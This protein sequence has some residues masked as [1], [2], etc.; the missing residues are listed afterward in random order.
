MVIA[1]VLVSLLLKYIHSDLEHDLFTNA[2]V[3]DVILMSRDGVV[4]VKA[5]KKPLTR[6][7]KR[8][9]GVHRKRGL[10]RGWQ[11]RLAKGWRKVGEG[12]A[13][14]WRRVRNSRGA[15]LETWFVTP[16]SLG[17]PAAFHAMDWPASRFDAKKTFLFTTS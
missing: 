17:K 13:R 3:D 11:K 4:L 16:W 9:P 10:E 6:V 8:V 15:R 2:F 5:S 14:G 12:L 1:N 7:S